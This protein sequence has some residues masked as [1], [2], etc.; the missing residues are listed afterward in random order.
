MEYFKRWQY[1]WY[2]HEGLS[3]RCIGNLSYLLL[4]ELQYSWCQ[5]ASP[6]FNSIFYFST[7]FY[8]KSSLLK[9][10]LWIKMICWH[11][12][13]RYIHCI[14]ISQLNRIV[15]LPP[16]IFHAPLVNSPFF[17]V[18]KCFL[19]VPA[20]QQYHRVYMDSYCTYAF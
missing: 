5:V 1:C 10:H 9:Y 6:Y 2:S 15:P 20:F 17:L 12:F 11:S 8:F 19:G 16:Q 7:F 3:I 18:N 14:V 13:D 4:E